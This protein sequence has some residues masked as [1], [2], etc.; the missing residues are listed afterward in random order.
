M[1]GG[2]KMEAVEDYVE[3]HVNRELEFLKVSL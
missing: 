3:R 1:E 2:I